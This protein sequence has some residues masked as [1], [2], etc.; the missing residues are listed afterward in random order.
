MSTQIHE[1]EHEAETD[2]NGLG[3]VE[4]ARIARIGVH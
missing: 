2:D 1:D 3:A 4:H